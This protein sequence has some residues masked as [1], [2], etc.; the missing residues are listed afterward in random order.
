MI[1]SAILEAATAL[2]VT[3]L[4]TP[5]LIWLCHRWQVLDFPGHLT[6]H[7]RPIP[8]L[9]G[10]AVALA[11]ALA[12][13]LFHPLPAQIEWPF[14]AS[15]ALIWAS[16]LV[17]DIRGL[18]PIPRLAAQIVGATLLWTAG[19]R[20]PVPLS[21]IPNLLLTCLF[22]IAI[23][24]SFNFLDGADSIAT[25]VAG[26]IAIAYAVIPSGTGNPFASEIAFSVAGACAG[27]LVYNLPPAKIFLGDS[28]STALGL[29][30][31]FLALDFWRSQPV[32]V[33]VPAL[34]FPFTL[35]ALPFLDAA[36]AILR[37]AGRRNSP[38]Q[39]DRNHFYDLLLA[40]GHSPVQVA[41]F[42]YTVAIVLAGISWKERGMSPIE[43]CAVSVLTFAAL[44]VI[45]V[46]LGSLR[47][48]DNARP[49]AVSARG[50][51]DKRL[52]TP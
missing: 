2:V 40:R 45:E 25:G 43:A 3:G 14:F 6:I 44:A 24:N 5:L 8:R 36:L 20:V 34:L 19:W 32:G 51:S 12:A 37:R 47:L 50:A 11:I 23:V 31:A 33:T 52:P 13:F 1:A 7:A 49:P 28:G 17:D 9:G 18:S 22:I 15:L 26:I 42:C 10:V 27:F 4:L 21:D 41:L 38:L 30:I 16:G 46:R 29:V 48:A 39:G 35:C